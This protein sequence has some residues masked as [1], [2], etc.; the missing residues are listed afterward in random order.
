MKKENWGTGRNKGRQNKH[1]Y[2]GH[3]HSHGVKTLERN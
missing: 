1:M 3:F 2:D